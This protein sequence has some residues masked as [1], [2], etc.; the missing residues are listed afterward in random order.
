MVEQWVVCCV[1]KDTCII[2][3]LF[4]QHSSSAPNSPCSFDTT[5]VPFR[6]AY[7]VL[8]KSFGS[9]PLMPIRYT[10]VVRSH[11]FHIEKT[12]YPYFSVTSC[13]LS[14]K[15]LDFDFIQAQQIDYNIMSYRLYIPFILES[16]TTAL[17]LPFKMY[18]FI[19][20]F[21]GS[22][23]LSP[24]LPYNNS[25]SMYPTFYPLQR[26]LFVNIR[27]HTTET[28]RS[29]LTFVRNIKVYVVQNFVFTTQRLKQKIYTQILQTFLVNS[30][31][32]TVPPPGW[33]MLKKKTTPN[34]KTKSKNSSKSKT[35]PL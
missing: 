9:K 23:F 3:T 13:S 20:L 27:L 17:A 4:F 10:P 32:F 18:A 11:T 1:K 31:N 7:P 28:N 15:A 33:L 29:L 24:I 14:L 22:S 30:Q 5:I 35:Y 6:N 34:K 16:R 12:P 26:C 21:L 25:L 2:I 19:V 8:L